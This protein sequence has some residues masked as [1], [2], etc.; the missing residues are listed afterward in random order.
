MKKLASDFG[1][2]VVW[3]YKKPGHG[4]G[5][6]DAMSSFGCKQQLRHE[7]V[8]NDSWFQN[9]EEMVQFLKKYFTNDSSKDHY[10]IDA[11]ETP[12]IRRKER[13]EFVLK[14]C[15]IFHVIAV[16]KHGKF[17]K[18]LH[19]RNQDIFNSLFDDVSDI[20][21]IIDDEQDEPAFQLNQ[22]TI[23]E[24]VE[25]GTFVGIRSP[26][27]AIEPFFIVEVFHRGVA[28]EN[29]FDSNGHCIVSREHYAEVGYLQKNN[30]KKRIVSYTSKKA[31]EYIYIFTLLKS[32]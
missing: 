11:A 27:N 10:L 22:D 7:I 28:Q 1:I 31:A 17:A 20:Q 2:T 14:P 4:C 29:L 21:E 13:E 6:V 30:E 5:L 19:Y 25:S 32:L 8:N 26:P 3:F 9:A 24:L 12:S 23:F 15:R 18:I 16:N